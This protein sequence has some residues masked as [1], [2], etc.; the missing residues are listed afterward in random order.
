MRPSAAISS[1]ARKQFSRKGRRELQSRAPPRALEQRQFEA[2]RSNEPHSRHSNKALSS[3]VHS[4][5]RDR[6]DLMRRLHPF[7]RN[8]APASIALMLWLISA[9]SMALAMGGAGGGGAGGGGGG[10]GAGGGAAGGGGGGMG[11]SD[12]GGGGEGGGS[13]RIVPQQSICA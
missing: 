11:G 5:P 3:R 1:W 4:H 13:A 10:G 6:E 9:G 2:R 12:G 7:G 8:L